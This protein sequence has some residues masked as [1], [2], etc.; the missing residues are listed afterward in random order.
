MSASVQSQSSRRRRHSGTIIS[1]VALS[2]AATSESN[3][4]PRPKSTPVD[5]RLQVQTHVVEDD[6][7]TAAVDEKEG[8]MEVDVENSAAHSSD[9][10][11]LSLNP[12]PT[13]TSTTT[14]SPSLKLNGT[15]RPTKP[16]PQNKARK[17]AQNPSL[18]TNPHMLPVQAHVPKGGVAT[19]GGPRRLYV[20]LEQACL[21]VYRVSTGGRSKN[22][23]D[24]DVKYAL[25]NCDDH[26][27]ILAKTG[28][29]I[30][31]AR[32]DITHQVRL[33]DCDNEWT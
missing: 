32:P 28:R 33:V 3:T 17:M 5:E 11:P 29:D 15:D 2:S 13:S 10:Q 14:T 6:S 24:G 4:I 16:L 12:H 23:R 8:N 31:D 7:E 30:A 21:E 25:L 19:T 20:I 9:Q 1:P 22:G 18:L 26:Q 27:G